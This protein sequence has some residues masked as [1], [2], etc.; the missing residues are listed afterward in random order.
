MGKVTSLS[1]RGEAGYRTLIRV[2]GVDISDP[3]G[4]QVSSQS[5]HLLNASVTRVALLR[6]P[7]GLM[8]GAEDRKSTRL[9]SSH[10]A[11]SY[12]VFCLKKKRGRNPPEP[13]APTRP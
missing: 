1:V 10:V 6:G 9:N 7:Q 8:Y 5:N 3:T 4:P 12:A 2:D 13:P 11:T